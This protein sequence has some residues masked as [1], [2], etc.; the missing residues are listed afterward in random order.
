MV[1]RITMFHAI[2]ESVCPCLA[3]Y[4]T[5]AFDTVRHS[6]PMERVYTRPMSMTG[7]MQCTQCMKFAY[8]V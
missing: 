2:D 5:K 4:L 7:R 1:I 6:T 8:E 3:L